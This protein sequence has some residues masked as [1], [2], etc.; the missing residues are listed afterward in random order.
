MNNE[1]Y[2]LL[3]LKAKAGD[4]FALI[5]TIEK[6]RALIKKMSYGDEDREQFIIEKLIKGIKNYKF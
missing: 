5:R 3:G 1:S 6:K 2:Y 4:E